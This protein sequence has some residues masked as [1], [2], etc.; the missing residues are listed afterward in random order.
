MIYKQYY[1]LSIVINNNEEQKIFRKCKTSCGLQ[2]FRNE[3][4][5]FAVPREKQHNIIVHIVSEAEN[6]PQTITWIIQ[7]RWLGT[8]FNSKN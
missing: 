6:I 7:G 5:L 3:I 2:I 1:S 4:S 8:L